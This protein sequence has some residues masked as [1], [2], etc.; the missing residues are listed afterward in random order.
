MNNE[1]QN[2]FLGMLYDILVTNNIKTYKDKPK[3]LKEKVNR[4]NNYL[5]KL[6]RV[7]DKAI[8]NERYLDMIKDLYY[9]RYIIKEE[10]IPDGYLKFLENQYLEQGHGHI[11]LVEPKTYKDEELKKEHIKTIIREQIDSL[12]NWLNYFL[13]KDSDY[14]PMWAKVWSFQGML[15]IGNLNKDKDGYDKRSKTT[16]NPFVS[17]DSEILGRCVTLIEETFEEKEMT[18]E[19]VKKLV[20]S[21]SFSKLYGKLLANKKQVKAETTDGI[22]IKYNQESEDDIKIKVDQGKEPEYIKLYN[23]LQ[24]YNTGWCT[25]GSRETA[26]KQLL[27]GDFYVYYSLDKNGEYKIPRLAIRMNGNQIGEIRGISEN[28]NIE[29][30]MELILEEKLKEFPDASMYKKKVSDMKLLTNIYNKY[31]N[32]GELTKDEL[33]FL[34]EIDYEILGFGYDKDPR[35]K[36]ILKNRSQLEDLMFVFRCSKDQIILDGD[37]DKLRKSNKPIKYFYGGLWLDGFTSTEGLVFPEILNGDLCLG[38][39]TD[40]DGLV[41][42]KT[43]SG[44]LDLS[45][46]TSAE[47]LIL[48]EIMNGSLYLGGL[49]DADGL[50]LPKT[51]SGNL[52]LSGLTSAEVLILPETINGYLFLSNFTSLVGVTL[53]NTVRE[54]V[55]IFRSHYNLDKVKEMQQVEIRTKN[56]ELKLTKK[57]SSGIV[58]ISFL[59]V[60]ILSFCILTFF[61]CKLILNK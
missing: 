51:I 16:I 10:N 9:D 22:W 11:N 1:E 55:I 39:L 3:D 31:L 41:L 58:S 6:K 32:K 53:P 50:V 37:F 44:N 35:I 7:Q 14:L 48:P 61:I 24:G 33:R 40:A 49:T 27:G 36:E 29:S 5:D 60:I 2:K 15:Q 47:V 54:Q 4:L 45:G 34:Y 57:I 28:Q 23:S 56:N 12:D 18:D 26:K 52:D 59:I 8:D 42:P 19:E 17:F 25:A 30:N 13:S 20:E 46:L 21:G 38:G 43:I